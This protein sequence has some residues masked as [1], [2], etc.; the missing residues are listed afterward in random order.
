MHLLA[1]VRDSLICSLQDHNRILLNV[2]LFDKTSAPTRITGSRLLIGTL[3]QSITVR[4]SSTPTSRRR[5]VSKPFEFAKALICI[6]T[7]SV[8]W[9]GIVITKH[10]VF[11]PSDVYF[12]F[13][14]SGTGLSGWKG[15]RDKGKVILIIRNYGL[16]ISQCSPLHLWY[17]VCT[18][19][20]LDYKSVLECDLTW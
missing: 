15:A 11:R 6:K 17:R 10:R 3:P 7:L 2:P 1:G 14:C 18:F 20:F 4:Y 5:G 16:Q 19:L 8:R 9:L 13:R 12:S